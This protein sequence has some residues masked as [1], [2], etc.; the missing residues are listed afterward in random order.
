M[1]FGDKLRDAIDRV[2]NSTHVDKNLIK[3]VVKEIQRALITSDVNIKLVLQISKEIEEKAF[4]KIPDT[5]T[6]KDRKS[7]V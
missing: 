1:G 7:V 5:V 2:K 4:E 3:E 6:R